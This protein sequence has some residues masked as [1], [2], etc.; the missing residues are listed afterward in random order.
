MRRSRIT[1]KLRGPPDAFKKIK[2][3]VNHEIVPKENVRPQSIG[4]VCENIWNIWMIL[5]WIV[6]LILVSIKFVILLHMHF[7]YVA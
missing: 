7:Y 2:G 3:A 4:L 1:T 5:F 6:N